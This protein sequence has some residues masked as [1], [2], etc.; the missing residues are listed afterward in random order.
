MISSAHTA[1]GNTA[2][3]TGRTELTLALLRRRARDCQFTVSADERVSE[4]SAARLLEVHPD[5]LARKRGEG[6][7]PAAYAVPLG[8]AKVTYRLIDLA[9]WIESRRE[10]SDVDPA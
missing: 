3:A 4:A 7:G 10:K 6:T 1:A 5:T 8:R 9:V 2:P